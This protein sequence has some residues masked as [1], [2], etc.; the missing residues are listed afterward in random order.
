MPAAQSGQE[1]ERGHLP[2]GVAQH[3]VTARRD[4]TLGERE[5]CHDG[6]HDEEARRDADRPA[7]RR[8]GEITAEHAVADRHDA[9]Q[10]LAER[11]DPSRDPVL[12]AGLDHEPAHHGAGDHHEG[13]GAER[14]EQERP[15]A[16]R[17]HAREEPAQRGKP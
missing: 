15:V 10:R 14:R 13:V 8:R 7:E 2:A 17:H 4:G 3:L 16:A 12:L 5:Q 9:L 6:Q 11:R 1:R